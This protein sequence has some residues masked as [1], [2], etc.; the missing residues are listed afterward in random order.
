MFYARLLHSSCKSLALNRDLMAPTTLLPLSTFIL[1][2]ALSVPNS[3]KT[4]PKYFHTETG[5]KRILSTQTSYSNPSSPFSTITLLLSALTFRPL[6]LH[7]S[8]NRPT[9]ALRSSSDSLHKTKSSAHKRPGNLHSPPPLQESHSL[10]SQRG[11]FVMPK[12]LLRH[13]PLSKSSICY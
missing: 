6:L 8:T 12:T 3:F 13:S 5:S 4:H 1:H 7:T 2:S 11:K 10:P 9:N